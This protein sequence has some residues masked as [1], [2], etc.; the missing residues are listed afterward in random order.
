MQRHNFAEYLNH[1]PHPQE[2][3]FTVPPCG[4]VLLNWSFGAALERK[5]V[6]KSNFLFEIGGLASADGPTLISLQVFRSAFAEPTAS[7]GAIAS[8]YAR[9]RT[10]SLS[11]KAYG[12]VPC[13][14]IRKC[15]M[16]VGFQVITISSPRNRH[17]VKY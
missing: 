13:C 4:E 14:S 6:R 17:H 12:D 7:P 2:S 1:H 5:R 11:A 9:Q 10:V 3:A 16:H 8:R 15:D